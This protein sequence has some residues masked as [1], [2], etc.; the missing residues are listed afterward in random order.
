MRAD[1]R[2]LRFPEP[3]SKWFD[4]PAQDGVE[5]QNIKLHA[6]SRRASSHGGIIGS[7]SWTKNCTTRLSSSGLAGRTSIGHGKR[8]SVFSRVVG[9]GSTGDNHSTSGCASGPRRGSPSL[10][11]ANARCGWKFQLWAP[12]RSE[13]IHV[14]SARLVNY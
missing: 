12:Q 2:R 11:C 13:N 9:C 8:S 1:D 7:F 6:P 4:V 14:R 10:R 3:H 5:Q